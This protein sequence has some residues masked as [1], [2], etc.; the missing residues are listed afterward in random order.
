M[1]LEKQVKCVWQYHDQSDSLR[2]VF[3]YF[4]FCTNEAIRISDEKN[5]TSRGKMHHE[6]Y[7][8]LRSNSEFLSKYVQCSIAVAKARLKL[9]RKTLKKK[10]NAKRPYVTRGLCQTYG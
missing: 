6:L 1:S 8:H 5:L 7:K 10:P 3:D 4:R 2:E 9:Y